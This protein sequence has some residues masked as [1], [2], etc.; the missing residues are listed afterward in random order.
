LQNALTYVPQSLSPASTIRRRTVGGGLEL[1][2]LELEL[3]ELE[4]LELG[5]ALLELELDGGLL[6]LDEELL[7]GGLELLELVE[8]GTELL[9]LDEELLGAADEL[10]EL[11]GRL[12]LLLDRLADEELLA[13]GVVLGG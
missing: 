13:G 8:P 6:E 7:D 2:L 12:L 11:V 5:G 3:L 4:L 1:E 10:L 9:E